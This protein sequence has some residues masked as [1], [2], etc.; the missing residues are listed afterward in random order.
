MNY[1]GFITGSIASFIDFDF[2]FEFKAMLVMVVLAFISRSYSFLHS[3]SV[4]CA[5]FSKRTTKMD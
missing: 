1:W 4:V 5:I 2:I 3:D